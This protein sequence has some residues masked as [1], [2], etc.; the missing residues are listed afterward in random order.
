MA[1]SFVEVHYQML[2]N[3]FPNADPDFLE[4][5]A[6][7][8]EHDEDG[9]Q[10]YIEDMLAPGASYP[11]LEEHIRNKKNR[12]VVSFYTKN[13]NVEDYL[14]KFPNRNPREYFSKVKTANEM[15]KTHAD[16]SMHYLTGR[17]SM[18]AEVLESTLKKNKYCLVD[19]V[20]ELEKMMPVHGSH[21]CHHAHGHRHQRLSIVQRSEPKEINTAFLQEVAYI[22]HEE[23]IEDYLITM[24]ICR[25]YKF[26]Q[27][28]EQGML[29]QCEC[30]FDTE[31][32]ADETFSCT[33][34]HLFCEP[35]LQNTNFVYFSQA[36]E[37]GM[38]CQ[39]HEEYSLLKCYECF[40]SAC[41]KFVEDKLSE[42]LIR[43]CYKCHRKFVKENTGCNHITCPVCGAHMCYVCR[44]PLDPKRIYQHFVGQ[45]GSDTKKC[46]LFSNANLLH[47]EALENV[48]Q[49][50]D[51]ELRQS[52]PNA[53][54]DVSDYLPQKITIANSHVPGAPEQ[55]DIVLQ[56]TMK[57]VNLN[58]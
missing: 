42:A 16:H 53:E 43:E 35:C 52:V 25:E 51:R 48:A 41:R 40:P 27:A 4:S 45:G 47:V 3:L 31:I 8:C 6:I 56:H 38:L 11:T 13:F 10:A 37:Q 34:G 26:E 21:C 58:L 57:A 2:K 54:V 29:C 19:T 23:E 12:E 5:I 15:G 20:F 39:L 50:V 22:E 28:K 46:P 30:C 36:K 24:A 9:L 7:E 18:K 17:F 14:K 32:L 49:A 1:D 44:Q 33:N 55:R